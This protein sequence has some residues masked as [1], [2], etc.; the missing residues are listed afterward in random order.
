MLWI[1]AVHVFR[2]KP[3]EWLLQILHSIWGWMLFWRLRVQFVGCGKSGATDWLGLVELQHQT[4]GKLKRSLAPANF[5]AVAS[6]W[7]IDA[8]DGSFSSWYFSLTVR[9]WS[10]LPFKFCSKVYATPL[11]WECSF[12]HTVYFLLYAQRTRGFLWEDGLDFRIITGCIM[13]INTA[14]FVCDTMVCW[15]NKRKFSGQTFV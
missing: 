10:F 6:S 14:R 15:S 3:V 7:I 1:S 9:F 2:I 12:S 13:Y 8:D 4:N 11:F 5:F